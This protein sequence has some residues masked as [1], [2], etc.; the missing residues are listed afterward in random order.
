M[1]IR[2][3]L[4]NV[5]PTRLTVFRV[6]RFKTVTAEWS[7]ILHDVSLPTKDCFTFEATE[8]LHVPVATFS[9]CALI[10]KYDLFRDKK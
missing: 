8:V 2:D 4:T 1:F 10:S 6:E 9:F 7:P 3:I 5:L